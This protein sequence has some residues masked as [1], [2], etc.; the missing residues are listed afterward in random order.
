[1]MKLLK[2]EILHEPSMD[3]V[4]IKPDGFNINTNNM[5]VN[6]K[7]K[8]K[9]D[10]Q[11]FI[12]WHSGYGS[13]RMQQRHELYNAIKSWVKNP[14]EFMEDMKGI[15]QRYKDRKIEKTGR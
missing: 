12:V 4:E 10:G 5:P 6:K 11:E 9:F 1:M 3:Q 14:V 7:F 15:R 13:V 2:R 8:F